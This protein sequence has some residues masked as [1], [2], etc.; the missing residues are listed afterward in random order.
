MDAARARSRAAG[1]GSLRRLLTVDDGPWRRVEA[2]ARMALPCL[3]ALP[4]ALVSALP[5]GP[6]HLGPAMPFLPAAA[7]FHW[8]VYRPDLMPRGAVFAIG[9]LHDGLTGAPLGMAAAALLA[10]QAAAAACR[11]F[12]AGATV[13]AAWLG[14]GALAAAAAALS[15]CLASLY[16]LAPVPAAPAAAQAC[17]TAACYP[18]L[19]RGFI[20]LQRGL[21]A[22]SP[23]RTR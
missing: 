13:A 11:P 22:P 16:H 1:G 10:L 4:L 23:A 20:A 19:A 21:P 12:F 5:L 2:Q 7:V 3:V 9:L 18:L 14:F 17:L 15:W 8:T 6:P